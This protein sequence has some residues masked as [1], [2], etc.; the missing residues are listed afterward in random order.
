MKKQILILAL[1]LLSSVIFAQNEK[2][3]SKKDTTTY[4]ETND[5]KINFFGNKPK[6]QLHVYNNK[7]QYPQTITNY[8]CNLGDSATFIISIFSYNE[9]YIKTIKPNE[10]LKK[11]R[12]SRLQNM[13]LELIESKIYN[14][15]SI[16]G[17]FYI[18][19]SPKDSFFVALAHF[20]RGNNY[21][22]VVLIKS[23]SRPTEKEIK[24]YIYSF[25][26]KK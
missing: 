22:Q 26:I 5:F 14:L 4:F 15:D 8:D 3:N 17:D 23:T 18:A 13:K 12:E 1:L 11:R 7:E 25:Q 21:Y 6:P 10:F 20:L 9:S 19:E 24:D 2:A 16:Q